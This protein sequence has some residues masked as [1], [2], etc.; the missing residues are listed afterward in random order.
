MSRLGSALVF[1]LYLVVVALPGQASSQST[2]PPPQPSADPPGYDAAVDQALQEFEAGNFAAAR[3]HF[4]Q[5]HKIFPNARTLRALGKTEY[6]LK[7]L[8]VAIRYLDQALKATVRPLT[9]PQRSEI[10]QLLDSARS[11]VARY[12]FILV[13]A[14]AALMI[15][16]A[17]ANL[18]ERNATV[19][20]AGDHFLEGHANGYYARG[21]RL[22]VVG[23]Q[24]GMV[25]IELR[26]VPTVPEATVAEDPAPLPPPVPPPLPP[27]DK[28]LR[29]KW[30]LWTSIA[31][32]VIAGAAVGLVLG[33]KDPKHQDPSGGSTG[34]VITVPRAPAGASQ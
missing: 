20:A 34:I 15:D 10:E 18:D 24:D 3:E 23:K 2:R 21:Q 26:P 29:K 9:G 8:P 19:L 6:E 31:G 27:Q 33:L 16:G 12:V 14:D 17:P 11:Q 28:P 32:V 7:N 25:R 22:H 1:A 5:A 4:Q 13:P 30:W